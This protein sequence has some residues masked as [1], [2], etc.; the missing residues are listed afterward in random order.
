MIE[1]ATLLQLILKNG[2]HGELK[3]ENVYKGKGSIPLEPFRPDRK[4]KPSRP[5]RAGDTAN[6]MWHVFVEAGAFLLIV[7]LGIKRH[8]Q[9]KQ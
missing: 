8:K 4:E 9:K 1:V 3:F 7:V 2:E 6:I 5:V